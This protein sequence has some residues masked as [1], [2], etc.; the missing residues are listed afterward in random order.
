[1][2]KK[3]EFWTFGAPRVPLNSSLRTQFFFL[4]VEVF[5]GTPGITGEW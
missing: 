4:L 2:K 5:G 1:M 3:A